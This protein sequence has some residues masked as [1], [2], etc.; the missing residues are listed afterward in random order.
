MLAKTHRTRYS[1]AAGMAMLTLHDEQA[2][3]H[4]GNTWQTCAIMPHT[5]TQRRPTN[6]GADSPTTYFVLAYA[7]FAARVCP[8][9]RVGEDLIMMDLRADWQWLVVIDIRDRVKVS[10]TCYIHFSRTGRLQLLCIPESCVN[11]T[12]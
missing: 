2:W 11:V 10:H 1:I 8:A 4:A 3:C 7:A 9:H 5:F 6:D 12:C